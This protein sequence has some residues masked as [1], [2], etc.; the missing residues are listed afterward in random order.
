MPPSLPRTILALLLAVWI[1]LGAWICHSAP[2]GSGTDE[3]IRYVAF[4]A[5]SNRWAGAEDA[6]AFR[7]DQF[8]YPPLYFLLFAPFFG[9]EPIFTHDYPDLSGNL[10][11]RSAGSTRLTGAGDQAKVPPKLMRLYRTA[12]IIS[13]IFGVGIAS[14]LVAVVRLLFPGEVG[15]WLVLGAAG[16]LLLLPQFLYFHTLVNNDCLVNLL[17]AL[18]VL[19]FI[20]AARCAAGGDVSRAARR[21]VACAAAVG[22]GLLTKQSAA[23]LLPLLP[24]LV[25]LRWRSRGELR[26]RARTIDALKH[27]LVLL[28]VT[29]A[30]G[31]WWVLRSAL[32][33]DPANLKAQRLTHGWAF[34]ATDLSPEAVGE[35]LAGV[36]RSFI[37]LFAGSYYGIPDRI[38][39]I[40]LLLAAAYLVALAVAAVRRRHRASATADALPGS[41]WATLAVVI[42]FNLGLI[43][44]Y[45][46][47]V[48]APQGRLLFP[49]LV[50]L[51]V[52]F[53]RSLLIVSGG[54]VRR[55][56]SLVCVTIAC[57]GGLFAWTFRQR[58]VP[59]VLQPAENLVPLG[60][61]PSDRGFALGP[62]WG[63][64]IRQPVLLPRGSLAGFRLP[65]RRNSFLPQF[66]TVVHARLRA[67]GLRDRS[68]QEFEPCAIGEND[69]V[70]RWTDLVLKAPLDLPG[71]TPALL[72]LRADKPWLIKPGGDIFYQAVA[73]TESPLL[74]PLVLN[75]QP[76]QLG[77]AL[78]AVYR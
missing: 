55:L 7:V 2:F 66:G 49:S 24:A 21:G 38:F 19:G 43:V 65:I 77:L 13:L 36:A 9:N 11:L 18:A 46:L 8:Y 35:V 20:A 15:E 25:W 1:G 60:V 58:M 50:A 44:V 72:L 6:A 57:L 61:V 12:K 31:G 78:T 40:Y 10:R 42:L 64:E 33:G 70:D 48:Q 67:P 71:M 53:A 37:A 62:I 29:V 52:L 68:D 27:L 23:A 45:N 41:G 32:A 39:A 34:I 3:S 26:A 14:C 28:A 59:A 73:L 56:A 74:K 5:A 4:A 54:S 76:S 16:S 22:L 17:S 47:Q 75:G 30:A 63:D 69:N 51:G